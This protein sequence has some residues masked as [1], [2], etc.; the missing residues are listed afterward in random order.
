MI[1]IS[2][3]VAVALVMR[4]RTRTV[5]SALAR[6]TAMWL[7]SAVMAAPASSGPL[8]RC[9][10]SVAR[11]PDGLY[12]GLRAAM[13]ATKITRHQRRIYMPHDQGR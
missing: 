8:H 1:L 5:R 3:V 12:L 9:S 7:T 13:Q 10:R 11:Y 4:F 6:T 2:L